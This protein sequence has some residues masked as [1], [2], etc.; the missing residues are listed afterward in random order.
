MAIGKKIRNTSSLSHSG[1]LT[2]NWFF[3]EGIYILYPEII[4]LFSGKQNFVNHIFHLLQKKFNFLDKNIL[5]RHIICG[6]ER[7]VV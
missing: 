6:N 7:F 3:K 4:I 1:G 5:L 2:T